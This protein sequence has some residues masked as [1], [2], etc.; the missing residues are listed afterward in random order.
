M[1]AS[2]PIFKIH[3]IQHFVTICDESLFEI[4]TLREQNHFIAEANERKKKK[5]KKKKKIN[6]EMKTPLALPG[7]G[8]FRSKR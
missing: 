6:T 2:S 5:K 3:K 7:N 8:H 1:N 4:S